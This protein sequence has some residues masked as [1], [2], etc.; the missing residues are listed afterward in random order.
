MFDDIWGSD[1]DN[2]M[3]IGPIVHSSDTTQVVGAEDVNTE[4]E[5]VTW[6]DENDG[7]DLDFT[8]AFA[9]Y[10]DS[11]G[12]HRV[13]GYTES[14][15]GEPIKR[16]AKSGIFIVD[17][18]PDVDDQTLG[19]QFLL[20]EVDG[21]YSPNIYYVEEDETTTAVPSSI[22]KTPVVDDDF[23]LVSGTN[24]I[25]YVGAVMASPV[26]VSGTWKFYWDATEDGS[27][28]VLVVIVQELY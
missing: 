28:S 18:L 19:A 17:E 13:T 10:Y 16:Y 25:D 5:V 2:K 26:A 20:T 11:D 8:V 23:I 12:V 22:I 4:A 24:T 27:L 6:F 7:V 14:V 21:E 9:L 3:F 15:A 1:D